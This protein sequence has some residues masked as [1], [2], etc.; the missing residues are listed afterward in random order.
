[1]AS[2]SSSGRTPR[3][4]PWAPAPRGHRHRHRRRTHGDAHHRGQ[5]PGQHQRRHVRAQRQRTV[6]CAAPESRRM[7]LNPPAAARITSTLAIGSKDSLVSLR[8]SSGHDAARSECGAQRDQRTSTAISS[9]IS[10]LPTKCRIWF[11]GF[12]ARPAHRPN[13]PERS[14]PRAAE[15]PPP[16]GWDRPARESAPIR[17]SPL[18]RHCRETSNLHFDQRGRKQRQP[19]FG[20]PL[21]G[22]AARAPSGASGTIPARSG[23]RGGGQSQPSPHRMVRPRSA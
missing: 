10:G 3:W 21:L 13:C 12:P 16:P 20:R 17:A 4:R 7:P 9:A 1:V 18:L 14:A 5:Q 6:A 19:V 2:T 22:F 15:W 23:Q 11:A 8:S